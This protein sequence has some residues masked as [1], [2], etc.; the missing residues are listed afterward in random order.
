LLQF[1]AANNWEAYDIQRPSVIMENGRRRI[2]FTGI[3]W[4]PGSYGVRARIGYAAEPYQVFLP[5][6]TR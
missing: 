5:L 1:N 2:W 3:G 4:M 6:I